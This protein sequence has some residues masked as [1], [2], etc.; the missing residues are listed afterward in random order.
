L[1]YKLIASLFSVFCLA[2]CSHTP[3]T[4]ADK[5]MSASDHAK[6]L[7]SQWK[8]GNELTSTGAVQHR[9]GVAMIAKGNKL[10]AEGNRQVNAGK[11]QF[12]QGKQ[13]Q[14]D[15]ESQFN[16]KFVSSPL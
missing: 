14:Q 7:S 11:N 6:V 10:V 1:K 8:Q 15:S 4:A 12:N 16:E 5:M 9:D 13:L 3:P 2:S